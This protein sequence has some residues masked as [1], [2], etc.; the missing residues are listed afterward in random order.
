MRLARPNFE[1]S[2][3]SMH[4]TRD[5]AAVNDFEL[6]RPGCSFLYFEL[7]LSS[8]HKTSRPSNKIYY[9]YVHMYTSCEV[10]MYVPIHIAHSDIY[11]M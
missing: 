9:V 7:A 11:A 8:N 3:H 1:S 4:M 10:Y 2:V 5:N 6:S